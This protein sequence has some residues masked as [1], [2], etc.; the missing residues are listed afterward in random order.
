[1][2]VPDRVVAGA[3]VVGDRYYFP[4]QDSS[5]HRLY[6]LQV[7]R[8]LGSGRR[9]RKENKR[10]RLLIPGIMAT[11]NPEAWVPTAGKL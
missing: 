9:R 5:V 6:H 11:I 3:V 2:I 8:S 10:L 7:N 4:V 1:M